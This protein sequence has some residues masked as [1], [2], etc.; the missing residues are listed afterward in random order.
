MQDHYP[1]GNYLLKVKQKHGTRRE[2]YSKLPIKKQERHQW[3]RSG[4]F[5]VNFKHIYNLVIVFLLLTLSR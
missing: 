2:I 3:P 4:V 5:V 1:V